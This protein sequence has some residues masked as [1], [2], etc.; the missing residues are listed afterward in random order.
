MDEII[1]A[2]NHAFARDRRTPAT[3]HNFCET[4]THSLVQWPKQKQNCP[5]TAALYTPTSLFSVCP[6]SLSSRMDE[7]QARTERLKA[8]R[9][10]MASSRE[11]G[12]SGAAEERRGKTALP[13]PFGGSDDRSAPAG[14]YTSGGMTHASTTDRIPASASPSVLDR[15]P[16]PPPPPQPQ[17][18]QAKQSQSF[19]GNVGSGRERGRQFASPGR[20]RGSKMINPSEYY[21]VCE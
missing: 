20:G 16:P 9:E 17:W 4:E 5:D 18:L 10:A 7:S 3:L 13:S 21:K 15:G 11:E 19:R 12:A 6:A 1:L 14:F 8:M 2:F